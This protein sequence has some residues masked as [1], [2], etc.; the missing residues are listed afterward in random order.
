MSTQ[1]KE[2]MSIPNFSI[3]QINK[4]GNTYTKR[5]Y[6]VFYL[7]VESQKQ[8]V[9]R[10]HISGGERNFYH[11]YAPSSAITSTEMRYDQPSIESYSTK[12]QM[13]FSEDNS[14]VVIAD[15]QNAYGPPVEGPIGDFLIPLMAFSALYL[16]V[17]RTKQQ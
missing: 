8:T 6:D 17:L 14:S 9:Y 12:E 4:R 1:S 16:L 5:G 10:D 11:K 7:S 13:P 2:R 3:D 15:R